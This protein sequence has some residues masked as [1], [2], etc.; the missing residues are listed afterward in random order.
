MQFKKA[1]SSVDRDKQ[2]TPLEL[3]NQGEWGLNGGG[4]LQQEAEE[5]IRAGVSRE[6]DFPRAG[7]EE[8]VRKIGG[9]CGCMSHNRYH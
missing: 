5:G 4:S 1:G 7:A 6:S 2:Y 3:I 9:P 8:F